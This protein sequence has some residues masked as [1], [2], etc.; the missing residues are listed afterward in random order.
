MT[1]VFRCADAALGVGKSVD[2]AGKL[3]QNGAVNVVVHKMPLLFP[4]QK[5]RFAQDLEML[6]YGGFRDGKLP[7]Q[8][9]DTISMP[10][11]KGDDPKTGLVGE[12][13]E[14]YRVHEIL[15]FN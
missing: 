14:Q 13:L 5:T 11:Q 4:D 8:R 7:R 15:L 10:Q 3:V 6:G 2:A 12:C 9:P 1:A